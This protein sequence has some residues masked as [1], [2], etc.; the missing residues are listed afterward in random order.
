MVEISNGIFNIPVLYKSYLTGPKHNARI[1]V[2]VEIFACGVCLPSFQDYNAPWKIRWEYSSIFW[3][4]VDEIILIVV[5][6]VCSQFRVFVFRMAEILKA[7][8]IRDEKLFELLE[9]SVDQVR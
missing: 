2:T 9:S 4:Q 6:L 7:G 5:V 1:I 8:A 3:T